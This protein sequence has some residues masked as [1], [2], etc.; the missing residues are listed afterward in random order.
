MSKRFS[1]K[2]LEAAMGKT[3]ADPDQGFKHGGEGDGDKT[4][5]RTEPLGTL[6]PKKGKNKK[7]SAL[8]GYQNKFTDDGKLEQKYSIKKNEQEAKLVST[9]GPRVKREAEEVELVDVECVGC[10]GTFQE[11]P[12]FISTEYYRC[13]GCCK[14]SKAQKRRKRTN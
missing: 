14:P 9:V 10:G 5:C 2:D 6:K 11:N 3:K 13:N 8:A 7:T 12:A 1:A 4:F